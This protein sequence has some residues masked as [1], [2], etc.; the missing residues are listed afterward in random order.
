LKKNRIYTW[1]KEAGG[2]DP[3]YFGANPRKILQGKKDWSRV[4][5][6]RHAKR[7]VTVVNRLGGTDDGNPGRCTLLREGL[8]SGSAQSVKVKTVN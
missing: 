5:F 6:L 7:K 2:G 4:V 1:E 3:P 8:F